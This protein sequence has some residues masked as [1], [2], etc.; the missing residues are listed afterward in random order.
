MMGVFGI[1]T[2]RRSI[3]RDY[4]AARLGK[5]EKEDWYQPCRWLLN[6]DGVKTSRELF[7]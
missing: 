4:G 3:G 7:F 1:R 2:C 5:A 6:P